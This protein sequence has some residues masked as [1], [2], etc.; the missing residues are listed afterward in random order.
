MEKLSKNQKD[1]I[2]ATLCSTIDGLIYTYSKEMA[3]HYKKLKTIPK[4][5]ITDSCQFIFLPL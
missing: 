2:E 5:C 3:K 4:K 1:S